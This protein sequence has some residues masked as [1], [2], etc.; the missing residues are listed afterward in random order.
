MNKICTISLDYNTCKELSIN[1]YR[2]V[3]KIYFVKDTNVRVHGQ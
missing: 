1:A 3:R 2:K